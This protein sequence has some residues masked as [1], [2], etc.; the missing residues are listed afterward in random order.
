MDDLKYKYNSIYSTLTETEK[1]L[2]HKHQSLTDGLI[3]T[4]QTIKTIVSSLYELEKRIRN[5]TT[6]GRS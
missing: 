4:I 1:N 5:E 2:M 3:E 6:S